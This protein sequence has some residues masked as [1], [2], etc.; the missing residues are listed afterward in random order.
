MLEADEIIEPVV[1]ETPFTLPEDFAQTV[2]GWEVPI[3]TLPEAVALYKGLQSEEGI[4]DNFV[5][6]GQK[7]GFGIKELERLFADEPIVPVQ[8]APVT[9][10]V[11]VTT[12]PEDP[13]RLLSAHE[14]KQ[15]LEQ[16]RAYAESRINEFTQ[17]QE[18]SKQQAFQA[19]QQQTFSVIGNWFKANEIHDENAQAII[20]RLGEKTID[21]TADSYDPQV[22]I[23]ALERGKEAYE[24]FVDTQAEARLRKKALVTVAQPTAVGGA[25]AGSEGDE[26]APD[27]KT[28]GSGAL[29]AAKARVRKRF[30]EGSYS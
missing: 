21:P 9:S 24:Q 3:E 22:A 11:P 26:T 8:T 20:A 18:A 17:Q 5:V 23:A 10:P 19:R 29:D 27:Y 16:E 2:Q 1:E 13:E 4:I 25:S 12:E 6:L 15:M 28:L 30:A 14:V 7:L